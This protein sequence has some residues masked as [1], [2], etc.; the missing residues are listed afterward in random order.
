MVHLDMMKKLNE[1]KNVD[2]VILLSTMKS[3]PDDKQAGIMYWKDLIEV[4]V[5]V[6]ID[7]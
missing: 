6:R 7:S 4:T 3:E 1:S 5:D 2:R